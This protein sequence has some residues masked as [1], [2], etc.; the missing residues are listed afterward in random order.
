[1]ARQGEDSVAG[2][3]A[4]T[5]GATRARRPIQL[6][7]TSGKQQTRKIMNAVMTG[8]IGASALI[9]VSVLMIILGYIIFRGLPALNF[10]FFTQNP[11]ALGQPGGGVVHAIVGSLLIVGLAS[12]IGI[13]IGLG[14]GIYLSEFGRGRF[15]EIIR[16]TADLMSGLPSIAIGVFAWT[17]LVVRV[18]HSFNA[19]AGAF[20]LAIIMIPI[21]TRTVEEILRLVPNGLREASLALGTP[22]WKTVTKVVMPV[23]RSGII[24]GIILSLARVGGETAPILLTVLGNNFFS[25]NLRAPMAALPLEIYTLATK[26]PFPDS[27][28]KAWGASLVLIIVIGWL[29][30]GVRYFSQRNQLR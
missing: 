12:L 29:S 10:A 9:G 7:E 21:I 14:A 30:V 20:A 16:F 27:Q 25:T 26:S 19:F 15:A 11:P 18:F 22:Q 13:P 1:M 17:I 8:L 23:A 28:V 5:A 6:T 3:I 4:V 24:T 2:Q